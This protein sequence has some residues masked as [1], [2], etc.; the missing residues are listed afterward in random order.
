[1]LAHGIDL[2]DRR[3]A[4]QERAGRRLLLLEREPGRRRDPVGRGAAGQKHQHQ[5]LGVRRVGKLERARGRRDAGLV[6][7]R[8]TRFD[9]R[10][11]RRRAAIAVA[12][13]RKPRDSL[14]RQR[15]IMTLGDLRH[16]A[17]GLAGGKNHQPSVRRRVGQVRR[18]AMVRMRGRNRAAEQRFEQ[19]AAW[20]G[21]RFRFGAHACPIP[22]MRRPK[23]C[24]G[25]R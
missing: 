19:G 15:F 17:G 25:S 10:N 22:K 16:R 8:M 5:V 6:R 3:A 18:Q 13:D 21:R 4:F 20:R 12:G 23:P 14:E 9:H 1:M 7:H 2:A 11:A 24:R